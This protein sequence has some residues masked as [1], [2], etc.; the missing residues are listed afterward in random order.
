M[1]SCL[2]SYVETP[3]EPPGVHVLCPTCNRTLYIPL[4]ATIFRCPSP[5]N[6]L[7]TQTSIVNEPRSSSYSRR[8][9]SESERVENNEIRTTRVTHSS[10]EELL[11]DPDVR[12]S[13][14]IQ[15][16]ETERRLQA[17]LESIPHD[18]QQFYLMNELLLQLTRNLQRNRL[19]MMSSRTPNTGNREEERREEDSPLSKLSLSMLPQHKFMSSFSEKACTT[20]DSYNNVTE[21][22]ICLQPYETGDMLKTLPCL[23]FFHSSCIDDWLSHRSTCPVDRLGVKAMLSQQEVEPI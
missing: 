11:N 7:L 21:C 20:S 5:C 13:R 15:L 10:T 22:V 3:D 19:L 8:Q 12:S 4:A 23:H 9:L 16:M 14:D 1:G 2:S 17:I 18:S 6:T